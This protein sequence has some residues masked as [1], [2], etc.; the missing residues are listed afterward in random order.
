MEQVLSKR[1][2]LWVHDGNPARPH[3]LLSSG[4]HGTGFANIREALTDPILREKTALTII[5]GLEKYINPKEV[6]VVAGS[7]Y[8]SIFLVGDVARILSYRFGQTVRSVFTDKVDPNGKEMEMKFTLEPGEVIFLVEDM[9][10]TFHTTLSTIDAIK[11][12]QP[13]ATIISYTACAFA[14]MSV[15]SYLGENNFTVNPILMRDMTVLSPEVCSDVGLCGKGSEAIKPKAR[16]N[17]VRLT[18]NY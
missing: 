9:Q 8:A 11:R 18:A 4:K 5:R 13:E 1:R 14:W 10:T 6:A 12:A 2:L 15:L 16:G 7:G 3:A 17:W